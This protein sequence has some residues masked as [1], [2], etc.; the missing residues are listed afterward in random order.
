MPRL[1]GFELH[2][3]WVPLTLF[4]TRIWDVHNVFP[5]SHL[6]SCSQEIVAIM[7]TP[8]VN[9]IKLLL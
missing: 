3:R 1:R 6:N 8:G 5:I 9:L 7:F 4:H 2:S